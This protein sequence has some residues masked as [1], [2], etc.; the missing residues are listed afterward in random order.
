MV[1]KIVFSYELYDT[2][3]ANSTDIANKIER[4]CS[5]KCVR[6]TTACEAFVNF[7]VSAGFSEDEI[8]KYF[9]PPEI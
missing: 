2:D 6:L 8:Y 1:E 9:M 4:T 7:M 5:G 3:I